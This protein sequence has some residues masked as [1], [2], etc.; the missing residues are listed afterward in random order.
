MVYCSGMVGNIA[1]VENAAVHSKNNAR[2][3]MRYLRKL[4]DTNGS[5][6][7]PSEVDKLLA[8]EH[9]SMYQKVSLRAAL[10]P[11]TETHEFV[12]KLNMPA[13]KVSIEE[14]MTKRVRNE[15]TRSGIATA[16]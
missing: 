9:L 12:T 11:G 7:S 16:Q 4:I 2:H 1:Y 5:I 6:L 15:Q 8:S 10:L 13:Q 14:L 3:W